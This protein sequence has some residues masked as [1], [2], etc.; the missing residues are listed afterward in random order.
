MTPTDGTAVQVAALGLVPLVPDLAATCP[1]A[2][3]RAELLAVHRRAF[4]M[5]SVQVGPDRVGVSLC[6][7]GWCGG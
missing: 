3:M 5:G 1:D 2:N 4:E 6:V 7:C